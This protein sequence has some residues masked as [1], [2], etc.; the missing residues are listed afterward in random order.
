[1]IR[2]SKYR[3]LKFT[4]L[5]WRAEICTSRVRDLNKA[6]DSNLR[7]RL[8]RWHDQDCEEGLAGKQSDM[9]KM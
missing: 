1:M 9:A 5:L 2:E 7:T 4:M 6:S 3:R 8:S